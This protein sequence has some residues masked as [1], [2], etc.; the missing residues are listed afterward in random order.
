M[1][2]TVEDIDKS[3]NS[4]TGD[5]EYINLQTRSRGPREDSRLKVY[6]LQLDRLRRQR[7]ELLKRYPDQQPKG[8]S[9]GRAMGTSGPAGRRSTGNVKTP[10][11]LLPDPTPERTPL[12]RPGKPMPAH[13]TPATAGVKRGSPASVARRKPIEIAMAPPVLAQSQ[14]QRRITTVLT[15]PST[16]PVAVTEDVVVVVAVPAP[17]QKGPA[18]VTPVSQRTQSNVV[19]QVIP[20]PVR[21]PALRP[22][23]PVSTDEAAP[24][25]AVLPAN[26]GIVEA[27][28]ATTTPS[29]KVSELPIPDDMPDN[30]VT[31]SML[32]DMI[33]LEGTSQPDP[34]D[35][36]YGTFTPDDYD[37]YVEPPAPVV[38]KKQT[39]LKPAPRPAA[40]EAASTK[41]AVRR[42]VVAKPTV[43]V[44][45]N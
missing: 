10:H 27:A 31:S 33:A 42:K 43:E 13:L 40:A 9:T 5:A 32:D 19:V 24:V 28:V 18:P 41:P 23:V 38:V 17:A 36:S 21:R 3:V 16:P 15:A 22:R 34:D 6:Q 8:V 35:L 1:N 37:Q 20:T 4:I 12:F 2:Q 29:L 39:K 14:L 44:G 7:E 45:S 25:E 26:Q 30:I 11:S